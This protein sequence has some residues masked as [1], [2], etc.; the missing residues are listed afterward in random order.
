MKDLIKHIAK[1]LVDH[2]EQVEILE[3]E[4]EQILLLELKV[5]KRILG[6]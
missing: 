6:R 3:V 4:G 1:A 2:P 5:A